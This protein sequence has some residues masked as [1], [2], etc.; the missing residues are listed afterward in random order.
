MGGQVLSQAVRVS[1]PWTKHEAAEEELYC[2]RASNQR[3]LVQGAALWRPFA[4]SNQRALV[5][6]GVL[7]HPCAANLLDLHV[8]LCPTAMS[9][10]AL[11][12][13]PHA[14]CHSACHTSY[15]RGPCVF[16]PHHHTHHYRH[17][18]HHHLTRRTLAPA[19][20]H[21][22]LSHTLFPSCC[23]SACLL[24]GSFIPTP[25]R[26]PLELVSRA[27]APCTHLF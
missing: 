11:C 27:P 4:A 5:Q 17:H 7:C 18:H 2:P 14:A 24:H 19:H 25:P 26:L 15:H 8:P 1:C 20:G 12:S 21:T 10:Q 16:Q 22:Q 9:R 23:A 3:A 6:G 13:M